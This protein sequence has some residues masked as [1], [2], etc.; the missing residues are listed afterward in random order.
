MNLHARL[1]TET[2]AAHRQVESLAPIKRLLSPSLT[3]SQYGQTL[4]KFLA[5]HQ[6][7]EAEIFTSEEIRNRLPDWPKRTKTASL[8][9]D[10]SALGIEATSS[11]FSEASPMEFAASV[12]ALYVLEGSTLGAQVITKHLRQLDF[13][14]DENL[15]YFN[16]YGADIFNYWRGVLHL[17]ETIPHEMADDVVAGAQSAFNRFE[18]VFADAL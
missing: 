14:G 9:K 15:H 13:I 5:L 16:H 17:L 10:L 8:T 12:G 3:Q 1:K 6:K 11:E 4:Q 18:Q 2:A 7:M